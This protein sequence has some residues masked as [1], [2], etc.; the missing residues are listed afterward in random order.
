MARTT[1]VYFID[2]LLRGF[3]GFV[4]Q[5]SLDAFEHEELEQCL[6]GNVAF[7]RNRL[8]LIQEGFR[9]TKRDRLGGRLQ[10]GEYHP[11]TLGVVDILR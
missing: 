1:L 11:T 3:G 6:I 8:E 9:Q 4:M 5:L 2:S 10:P 7:V